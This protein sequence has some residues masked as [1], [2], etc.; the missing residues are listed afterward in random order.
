MLGEPHDLLHD[1]PHHA[2]RIQE[3]KGQ[4]PDFAR[5]MKEYDDLDADIRR[6]EE[7]G[8]PIADVTM[9]ALK[10]HRVYLK[11]RLYARLRG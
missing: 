4:D 7:L 10:V 11:D 5:L 8:Q 3:L 6:L 2:T 1:F 9:E